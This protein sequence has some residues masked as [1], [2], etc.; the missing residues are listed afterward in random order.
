LIIDKGA[1]NLC[2]RKDN[3]FNKWCWENWISTCIILKL[4]PS[5]SPCTSINWKW[6][7]GLNIR[8][9][10]VKLLQE[11]IGITLDHKGI[12]NNFMNRIPI[13]SN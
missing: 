5:L 2:W 8:S 4:D 12:D 6:I 7:K 10:T 11:K 1:Q 13:L 9:E 3:L